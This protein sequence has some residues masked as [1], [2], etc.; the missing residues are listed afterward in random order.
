MTQQERERGR[1]VLVGGGV[2]SGKSAFA[3][4]RARELGGRRAFVATAQ[5][6]D[7]EMAARI[8]RHREERGADFTTVEAPVELPATVERLGQEGG[9]DVAVIDCLTLWLSNLLVAGAGA[10]DAAAAVE[11]LAG[12]LAARRLHVV[13][14]TNEVGMGVIPESAL[15]RTFRDVTGRAHQRLAAIA[16]E[17]HF[18]A[19]GM[20]LRLHP[21]PL[22]THFPGGER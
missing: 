14:V 3:L 2:R 4:R 21:A 1:L 18:A 19:L 9:V 5:G 22:T 7:E 15:G 6:L 8:A 17:I 11:R 13:L 10:A 16:D 20:M 12:V